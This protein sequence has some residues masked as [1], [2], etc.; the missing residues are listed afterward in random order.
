MP[1]PQSGAC[2]EL[3]SHV[4]RTMVTSEVLRDLC[5]RFKTNGYVVVEDYL[6]DYVVRACLDEF[7]TVLRCAEN[8]VVDARNAL[9]MIN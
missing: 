5:E 8:D 7:E 2:L 4:R 9:V 1:T 6:D 3:P